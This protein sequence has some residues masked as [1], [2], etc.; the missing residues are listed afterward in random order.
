MIYFAE[1]SDGLIKI[2]K[3][4]DYRRRVGQLQSQYGRLKILGLVQGDYSEERK[5][6]KQFTGIRITGEWFSADKSLLQF[7]AESA[8]HIA[9]T[10]VQY[11]NVTKRIPQP[12]HNPIT[13]ADEIDALKK[14][15]Q[16]AKDENLRWSGMM[17]AMDF[18]VELRDKN[19]DKA[20]SV[21][22]QLKIILGKNNIEFDMDEILKKAINLSDEMPAKTEKI[23]YKSIAKAA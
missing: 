5:L 22:A 9:Y 20:I 4:K 19:M 8:Q 6:H 11:L 2:G 3:A 12:L 18:A 21:I 23:D 14:E 13:Q 10:Q 7:I 15:L 17:D 16:A 1:R